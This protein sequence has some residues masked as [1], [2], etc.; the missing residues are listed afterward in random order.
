MKADASAMPQNDVLKGQEKLIAAI[1][2]R[3]GVSAML[4]EG[5]ETNT[6]APIIFSVDLTQPIFSCYQN[7][8][9]S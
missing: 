8:I 5:V 9:S 4:Y 6:D 1:L 3:S 7:A 2:P